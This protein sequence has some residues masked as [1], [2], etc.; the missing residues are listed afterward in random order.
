MRTIFLAVAVEP[1]SPIWPPLPQ[2]ASSSAAAA[3]PRVRTVLVDMFLLLALISCLA[4]RLVEPDRGHQ[5]DRH[6]DGLP[7]DVDADDDETLAEHGGD[8]DAEDGADDG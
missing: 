3:S 8:E 1:E 5:D 6:R 2:A 4:A 7:V